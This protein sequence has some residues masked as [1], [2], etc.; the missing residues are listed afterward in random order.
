M[1][2]IDVKFDG[3]PTEIGN[4]ST[5]LETLSTNITDTW[6]SEL[7]SGHS[8]A[9]D[10]WSGESATAFDTDATS[11]ETDLSDLSEDVSSFKKAVDDL[12]IELDSV[13]STLETAISD[14]TTYGL[15]VEGTTIKE[16]TK[17]LCLVSIPVAG[18]TQQVN[19]TEE[20]AKQ[21]DDYN[22]KV[23]H[24]NDIS[25]SVSKARDKEQKAHEAFQLSCFDIEFPDQTDLD[26]QNKLKTIKSW[27]G[28][29]KIAAG[30]F[31]HAT[32][33]R[34]AANMQINASTNRTLMKI[35]KSIKS[36]LYIRDVNI[37]FKNGKVKVFKGRHVDNNKSR[38]QN[39]KKYSYK[40]GEGRMF[41]HLNNDENWETA[42]KKIGKATDHFGGY[43]GKSLAKRLASGAE[44]IHLDKW[45][46]KVGKYASKAGKFLGPLGTA[47]D[48]GLV[49]YDAYKGG[50]EQWA[51]DSVDPSLTKGDKVARTV[52]KGAW[53]AVPAAAEAAGSAAGSSALAAAFSWTGPGAAV[54]G[55]AGGYIGGKLGR[56]GGDWIHNTF[57]SSVS[58]A[59]D[60][61]KPS[62]DIKAAKNWVSDKAKKLKFW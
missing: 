25:D 34:L 24:Y 51:R 35:R 18:M 60:N 13:K 11:A 52:A 49:G 36:K 4:L 39:H 45:G 32:L 31:K 14:A 15:T 2:D 54:A 6:A 37:K 53:D 20:E 16:P 44:K 22:E 30:I 7:R 23:K 10:E 8:T 29:I 38:L 61:W 55:A 17:P 42:G 27:N 58:K 59:I 50:S 41:H 19:V 26:V 3:D 33:S 48:V 5:S 21:V 1:S 9:I 47:I 56:M 40:H 57:D 46:P 43:G 28:K 12:K 62:E